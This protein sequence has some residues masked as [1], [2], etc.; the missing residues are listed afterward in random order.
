MSSFKNLFKQLIKKE[1]ANLSSRNNSP[2]QTPTSS[3]EPILREF[4]TFRESDL[5]K[6]LSYEE[7]ILKIM[8]N[9]HRNAKDAEILYYHFRDTPFC[10]RLLDPKDYDL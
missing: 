8:A 7:K 9:N 4:L 3:R 5:E 10:E 2:R 6:P 1:H